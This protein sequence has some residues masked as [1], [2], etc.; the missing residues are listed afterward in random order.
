MAPTTRRVCFTALEATKNICLTIPTMEGIKAA[1][2]RFHHDVV[3]QHPYISAGVLL[4]W[5]FYPQFP[6]HVLYFVLFVIPRSII[7]GILTC[8]GF[9]RGGVREDS[10]A[11]RYQ[12]RRY[13]GA[14]PSSGLFAGAQS[15]G[16]ANRAPLSAQSQQER[17]SHPIIG[18]LWRLLAFLCLYAS[19]VVLL[20]YGE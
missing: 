6:F 8:L 11:S 9:E 1:L 14:T 18:V 15:Y 2:T 7:L 19:L 4:F 3:M 10:I 13:G 16:A 5:A 20:K 17:P 12:A